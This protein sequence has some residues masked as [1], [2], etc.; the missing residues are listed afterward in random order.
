MNIGQIHGA[1]GVDRGPDRSQPAKQAQRQQDRVPV[2]DSALISE[3]SRETLR[4]FE[5]ISDRLDDHSPQRRDL[6][7]EVKTRLK[8][9]YLD[10]KNVFRD[11]ARSLLSEQ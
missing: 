5:G 1:G 4:D 7:A 6:V 11:V 10:Q 3:A 2:E 8:S 9:G